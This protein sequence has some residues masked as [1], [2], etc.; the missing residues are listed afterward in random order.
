MLKPLIASVSTTVSQSG[1]V[2][3]Y[4]TQNQNNQIVVYDRLV[5]ID[6]TSDPGTVYFGL[7][8]GNDEYLIDSKTGVTK[9]VCA[10][11]T[12]SFYAPGHYIPFVRF[13]DA[14]IGDIVVF[15]ILGNYE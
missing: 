13:A 14:Q 1:G 2:D 4:Y 11:V 3:L 7:K 5:A 8:Y 15:I 10:V 6:L 9:G 12:P